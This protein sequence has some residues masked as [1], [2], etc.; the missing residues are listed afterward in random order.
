VIPP[1]VSFRLIGQ[2]KEIQKTELGG[3]KNKVSGHT[4]KA[5]AGIY[6]D[7]FSRPLWRLGCLLTENSWVLLEKGAVGGSSETRDETSR[8]KALVE[9]HN[10]HSLWLRKV[11]SSLE[12]KKSPQKI[13]GDLRQAAAEEEREGTAGRPTGAAARHEEEPQT[14]FDF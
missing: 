14:F 4:E 12:V 2:G 11:L 10:T 3:Q 6:G 1:V 8:R 9:L 5:I 7:S 13:L